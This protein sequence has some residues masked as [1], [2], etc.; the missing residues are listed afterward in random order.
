MSVLLR[1]GRRDV[2]APAVAETVGEGVEDDIFQ[3]KVA[4]NFFRG[5]SFYG[6]VWSKNVANYEA[7]GGASLGDEKRGVS[8]V[9]FDKEGFK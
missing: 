6:D 8:K 3:V 2:G 9:A 5:P 7:V 1:G 4:G